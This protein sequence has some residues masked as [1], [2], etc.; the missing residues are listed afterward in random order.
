MPKLRHSCL[1]FWGHPEVHNAL[2]GFYRVLSFPPAFQKHLQ[3][4]NKRWEKGRL[5]G[6]LFT[7]AASKWNAKACELGNRVDITELPSLLITLHAQS[8]LLPSPQISASSQERTVL[9]PFIQEGC[10]G[11]LRINQRFRQWKQKVYKEILLSFCE[12]SKRQ[13]KA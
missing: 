2:T 7:M 10:Q 5:G 12:H 3:M 1:P 13:N 8:S 4:N 11:R 6:G 9:I